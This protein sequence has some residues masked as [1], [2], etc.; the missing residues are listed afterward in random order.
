LVD[1]DISSTLLDDTSPLNDHR[2][3]FSYDVEVYQHG[4]S[5]GMLSNRFGPASGGEHRTPLY[6]IFG[7]ALAAA[8]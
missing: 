2:R 4:A 1:G 6:L 5:V 8:Y 3:F 7:A